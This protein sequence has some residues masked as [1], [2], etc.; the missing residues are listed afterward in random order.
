MRRQ[1]LMGCCPGKL[2]LGV[3]PPKTVAIAERS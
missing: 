2:S 3:L 1:R